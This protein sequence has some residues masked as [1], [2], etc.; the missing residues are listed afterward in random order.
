[1][2][3]GGQ[4]NTLEWE[5]SL[6]LDWQRINV[7]AQAHDRAAF[8]N[9]RHNPR[10][11]KRVP[12]PCRAGHPL[13]TRLLGC[14]TLDEKLMPS[15]PPGPLQPAMHCGRAHLLTT[16]ACIMRLFQTVLSHSE[17]RLE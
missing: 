7:C 9:G 14:I 16:A 3:A 5:I 13:G 11:S 4:R 10:L 1:M 17:G 15:S 2:E 12:V 8:A 6:L